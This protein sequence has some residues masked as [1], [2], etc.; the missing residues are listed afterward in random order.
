MALL[1][2]ALGCADPNAV[3]VRLQAIAPADLEAHQV[4]LR[5]QVAGPLAGLRYRWFAV[6]GQNDP[7]DSDRP[8]TVFTFAEGATRDR[9]TLEV[10]RADRRVARDEIDVAL[11]EARARRDTAPVAPLTLT[12]TR[13]P[14]ADSG[15]PDTRADIAGRVVGRVPTGFRVVLYARAGDVWYIQPSPYARHAIA[16]DGTWGSWTHT[17]SSYAAMVVQPGFVPLPR[18][19]VL[20]QPG[21]SVVARTIVDGAAR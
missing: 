16:G 4:A 19:D 7:Q 12:I 9:V 15:G 21:G 6:A 3:R 8:E 1:L 10:W 14:P 17:G 11:D 18:Y 13:V 2:G 5:A 20:P